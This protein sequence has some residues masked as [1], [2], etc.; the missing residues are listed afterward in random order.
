MK[1]MALVSNWD[2]C[3]LPGMLKM[4][5]A[6]PV[7]I[8]KSG[9][10][11]VDRKRDYIEQTVN[12]HSFGLIA[13]KGLSQV[14]S[15]VGKLHFALSSCIESRDDAELPEIATFA[16]EFYKMPVFACPNKLTPEALEWLRAEAKQQFGAEAPP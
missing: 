15:K 2:E 14:K 10:V 12:I 11:H 6:K 16:V 1:F 13:R 8:N 3:S 4:Y 9:E 7:L 5:N